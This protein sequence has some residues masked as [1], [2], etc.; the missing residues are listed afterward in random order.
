[1]KCPKCNGSG[2]EFFS[3][4]GKITCRFCWGK[5]ELDWIEIIFGVDEIERIYNPNRG[6]IRYDTKY[7]FPSKW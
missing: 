7:Q 1:M 3:E 6:K 4:K 2:L 5:K